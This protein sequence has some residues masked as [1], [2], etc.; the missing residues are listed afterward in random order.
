MILQ[1]MKLLLPVV[2]GYLSL[3]PSTISAIA[4]SASQSKPLTTT[5]SGKQPLRL[6]LPPLPPGQPPGG[7]RYG[8]VV[9]VDQGKAGVA[10]NGDG[11]V[12]P[13]TRRT[14]SFGCIVGIG[15]CQC[16]FVHVFSL[17]MS[18]TLSLTLSQTHQWHHG[19]K[20]GSSGTSNSR[21]PR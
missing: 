11:V 15:R 1:P 2:L 20:Q 19:T 3:F 18:L 9:S 13:Y 16:R 10:G 4:Q 5:S 12:V 17:N 14:P 6:V 21:H 8:G 7:R